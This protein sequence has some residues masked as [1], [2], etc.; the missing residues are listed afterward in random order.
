MKL[1]V[2]A[3]LLATTHAVQLSGV[4]AK[5]DKVPSTLINVVQ[6]KESTKTAAKV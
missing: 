2:I 1:A 6:K 3:A 4:I 5:D